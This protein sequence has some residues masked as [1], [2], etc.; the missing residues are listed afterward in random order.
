[1]NKRII[2]A[3]YVVNMVVQ[4]LFSLVCPIGLMFGV[5]YFLSTKYGI[6]PWI[7][8]VM[9]MTGVL[10]GIYSMVTFIIKASAAVAAMEKAHGSTEN[11]NEKG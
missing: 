1:M 7:Y 9:I 8:V 2:P 5:A 3:L 11:K 10:V 6:G 4:S